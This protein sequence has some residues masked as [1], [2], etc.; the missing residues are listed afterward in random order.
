MSVTLHRGDCLAVMDTLPADHFD[1]V[2]TDPPY[3]LTSIVKRFSGGTPATHGTDG[4][5]QRGSKGF[6]GQTWDGGDIAFRPETWAKVLR[7]MKPGAHLVAFNHSRTYH[8]M[9]AAIAAAGFEVR[10]SFL[11]LYDAGPL[12]PDFLSTL[13]AVQLRALDRALATSGEGLLAWIYGTGFPHSHN[14]EKAI[15]KLRDDGTEIRAVTAWIAAA[16]RAAGLT[17]AAIDDHFGFNG[18]AGHWCSGGAQAAIPTPEQWLRLLDLLAAEPPAEIADLVVRLNARKGTPGEDWANRAVLGRVT[19]GAISVKNWKENGGGGYGEAYDLTA[20]GSDRSAA[21]SGWGT[22]LKPAFEPIVLARK[23]L[24][25]GSVARQCLATGTGGLN[26]DA[27]LIADD[28]RDVF[29][30]P[31]RASTGSHSLGDYGPTERRIVSD[32][33][34]PANICH[35]GSRE[36]AKHFPLDANGASTARFFYSAKADDSDRQGSDHPTV[37]PQALMRWLVRLVSAP[38]ARLLDPF[39]GSGSTGWA[40]H[41]EGRAC[42]LIEMTEKYQEHIAAR[43]AALSAPPAPAPAPRWQLD[44][45]GGL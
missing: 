41:A 21:W 23:P 6:L 27:A 30:A 18:M 11:H 9:A 22:A 36:V 2:V 14:I 20:A 19:A 1:A 29:P 10:D 31:A 37:K 32:G 13:D 39:G 42:D 43:I 26:I 25:E 44:L 7:V 35:D 33:L 24:A 45:F 40:A 5:F 4:L 16:R 12:W 38:G 15:D 8:D 17:T 34:W 28:R 3:H